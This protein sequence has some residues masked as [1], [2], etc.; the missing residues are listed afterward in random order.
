MT[1]YFLL[2]HVEFMLLRLIFNIRVAMTRK[3]QLQGIFGY[4]NNVIRGIYKTKM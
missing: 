2:N 4:Y 1:K 3:L